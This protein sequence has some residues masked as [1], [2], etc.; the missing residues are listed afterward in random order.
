[1]KVSLSNHRA[2]LRITSDSLSHELSG[3]NSLPCI[4]FIENKMDSVAS[5]LEGGGKT[6]PV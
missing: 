2:E 5:A 6:S 4:E 3:L 1:M